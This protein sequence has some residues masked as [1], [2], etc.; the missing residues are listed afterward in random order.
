MTF[1][2]LVSSLPLASFCP[3][4]WA[5]EAAAAKMTESYALTWNFLFGVAEANP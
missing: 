2:L 4:V 3:A 5:E 1:F